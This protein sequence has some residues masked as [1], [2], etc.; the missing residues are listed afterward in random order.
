MLVN[1]YAL[2]GTILMV[3]SEILFVFNQAFAR[4]RPNNGATTIIT[5]AI[6]NAICISLPSPRGFTP[7]GN[8]D[9]ANSFVLL[10]LF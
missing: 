4:D 3:R 10:L 8:G 2:S 6:P 9:D 1:P 5:N 7:P